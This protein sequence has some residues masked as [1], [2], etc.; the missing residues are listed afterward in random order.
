MG[1]DERMRRFQV[2]GADFVDM[3]RAR[4]EEVVRGLGGWGGLTGGKPEDEQHEDEKLGDEARDPRWRGA[5]QLLD[6]VCREVAAQLGALGIATT[7]DIERLEERL[8]RLE[9][10]AAA[11]GRPVRDL[12]AQGSTGEA[13]PEA[14]RAGGTAAG[15]SGAKAKAPATAK[16]PAAK[17][18]APAAR[19]PAPA[20]RR[21]AP[22]DRAAPERPAPGRANPRA[23][24]TPAKRATPG[25]RVG[26][27][28]PRSDRL[29]G[30]T[31]RP[32]RASG[33]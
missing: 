13:T 9:T 18:P 3:A 22:A 6:L 10:A 33:G 5:D 31:A 2:V 27:E 16:A 20:A 30:G 7:A 29:P 15:Q 23:T 1:P 4:A 32:G 25:A 26:K 24:A 12:P 19:R 14:E 8:T 21:T 17:R 28:A 11:S